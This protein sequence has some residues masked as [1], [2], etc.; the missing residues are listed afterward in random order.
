MEVMVVVAILVILAGVGSV[1]VFHYL[2]EAKI[3]TARLNIKNIEQAVMDYK[4]SHDD[5]PAD[6]TV[7]TQK[8]G[9]KNAALDDRQLIDPWNQRY[10]LDAGTLSKTGK[11]H[12]FSAGPP[13]SGEVIQNFIPGQ[14]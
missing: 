5:W 2:D 4:L 7:L 10:Q 1:A 13:G 8:E 11:P 12:I 6:L 9:S 3:K 14:E